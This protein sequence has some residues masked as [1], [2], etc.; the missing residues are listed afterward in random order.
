MANRLFASLLTPSCSSASAPAPQLADHDAL[1][2]A[3]EVAHVDMELSSPPSSP[4]PS[5]PATPHDSAPASAGPL[6]V[7]MEPSSSGS[8]R[9]P[10]SISPSSTPALERTSSNHPPASG[11]GSTPAVQRTSRR[12]MMPAR[13]SQVSSLLAG[14]MLE[15]ELMLLDPASSPSTSA[16]PQSAPCSN[17][18]SNRVGTAWPPGRNGYDPSSHVKPFTSSSIVVLTSDAQLL[19]RAVFPNAPPSSTNSPADVQVKAEKQDT[20]L[21]LTPPSESAAPDVTAEFLKSPIPSTSSLVSTLAIKRQQ[22]IETPD[23]KPRDDI[24]YMPKTRGLRSEAAEDTSDAAYERRHRKPETAEK[25]QRKAEVDRLS[26]DRQKLL[27]RIEQL[28]T[29]EARMLQPIVVARDQ[30]R[31]EVSLNDDELTQP[32]QET[33]PLHQ[34][35]E[36]VRNELLA[37]AYETLKR[38]DLLLS[39]SNDAKTASPAPSAL[40][41]KSENATD[42]AI[43]ASVD[44]VTARSQSPRLKIRI[45]GGRAT[46]ETAESASPT[47]KHSPAPLEKGD[48]SRRVSGRQPKQRVESL[49]TPLTAAAV[50]A[51][52]DHRRKRRR[53]SGAHA[54]HESSVPSARPNGRPQRAAAAAAAVA[55]ARQRLQYAERSFSDFEYEDE[56]DE[57]K[58]AVEEADAPSS[59]SSHR[60]SSTR[61]PSHNLRRSPVKTRDHRS[62]SASSST[63]TAS[64]IGYMYPTLPD[65]GS[66][67]I[68]HSLAEIH[69]SD[70]DANSSPVLA[71]ASIAAL[72]TPPSK[73]LRL[74]LSR[75]PSAAGLNSETK[76]ALT[77]A[78]D[79]DAEQEASKSERSRSTGG[80]LTESEAESILAAFLGT[81]PLGKSAKAATL[82]K[83]TD[84]STKASSSVA[85]TV[86]A[87]PAAAPSSSIPAPAATSISTTPSKR[88]STRRETTQSFG[89]KPPDLLTKTAQFDYTVM[90]YFRSIDRPGRSS[91]KEEKGADKD[92]E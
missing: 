35:I 52:D 89:E 66:L 90:G 4:P 39:T 11:S 86:V 78:L 67:K 10:S 53:L 43:A 76:K 63:S 44:D 22:L 7:K 42:K 81:T 83:S 9:P 33:K 23:F 29:V 48:M 26:R 1:N 72:N 21:S 25:R 20:N 31:A 61:R 62:A 15:E 58:S 59:H 75:S 46:W 60:G 56:D 8:I 87:K 12:R 51:V 28:K 85:S 18:Q 57:A 79:S 38:Y 64:S 69:A 6:S 77:E 92:Q 45:K 14:S 2:Q 36:D 91:Y 50:E 70:P 34:R 73:K 80:A 41:T 30:V 3:Q 5:A 68:S 47:P 84:S 16:F 40:A 19:A 24:L 88:R 37:D 49:P 65:T 55:S 27:S 17:T 32:E 71:A 13:L 82:A 74:V 54:Y